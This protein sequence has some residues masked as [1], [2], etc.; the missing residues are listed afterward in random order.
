MVVTPPEI[1]SPGRRPPARVG[2]PFSGEKLNCSPMPSPTVST[3]PCSSQP[4]VT[5][6]APSKG[7]ASCFLTSGWLWYSLRLDTPMRSRTSRTPACTSTE[8]PWSRACSPIKSPSR[9]VLCF[10][11]RQNGA[12]CLPFP[13]ATPGFLESPL[14]TPP[15]PQ[16]A[17]P[18]APSGAPSFPRTARHPLPL[19]PR[20]RTIRGHEHQ[21]RER[22]SN[23]CSNSQHIDNLHIYE[24]YG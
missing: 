5:W 20:P 21:V 24:I 11:A 17:P 8:P 2:V 9:T 15:L 16:T 4:T 14:P 7:C 13:T 12:N 19:P 22:T 10:T 23:I 6:S 3:W 18:T 1:A